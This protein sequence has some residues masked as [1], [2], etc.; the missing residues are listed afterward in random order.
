MPTKDDLYA[1]LGLERDA[2]EAAIKKSY[3]KLA[4]K[5]H[6]DKGGDPEKFK[7]YAE[8]YAVLSDA[9][10]RRV[11]DATGE[12]ELTEMDLEE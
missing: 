2:D 10:K 1:R 12:L 7:L 9:E 3:R 8:A 6:P 4:L 5:H 11:Y